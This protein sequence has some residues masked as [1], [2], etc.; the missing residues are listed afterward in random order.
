M[1]KYKNIDRISRTWKSPWTADF[2]YINHTQL[3]Y[4]TCSRPHSRGVEAPQLQEQGGVVVERRGGVVLL[5]PPAHK[6]S[7]GPCHGVP[8]NSDGWNALKE[9]NK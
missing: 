2:Q 6:P 5:P 3:R 1:L 4:R 7:D 9:K 8:C